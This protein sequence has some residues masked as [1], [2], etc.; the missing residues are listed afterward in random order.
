MDL[1][2]QSNVMQKL[3]SKLFNILSN[4][5]HNFSSKE[6]SSFNFMA[7][8]TICKD[9][10]AQNNNLSLFPL[11]PHQFA[12]KWWD[13][14]PWSSF[15]KCCILSQLFHSPLS[16]SSRDFNSS[17]RSSLWAMSSAYL[18]LFI[19]LLEILIP[20]CASSSLAFHMMYSAFKVNKQGDNI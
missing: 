1:F 14:M 6:Q 8:V 9:F 11:F 3:S 15:F 13:Q 20:A 4:V 5:G 17:L 16:L 18:R 10:G 2:H 12:M 19:F 7:A